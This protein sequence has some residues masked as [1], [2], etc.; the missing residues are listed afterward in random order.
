MF[1]RRQYS[2]QVVQFACSVWVCVGFLKV[3]WFPPIVKEHACPVLVSYYGLVI[4]PG[5]IPCLC[6]LEIGSTKATK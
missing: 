1:R 6:V 5:C 2:D 4:C 3:L